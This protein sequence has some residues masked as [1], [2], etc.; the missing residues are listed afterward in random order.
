MIVYNIFREKKRKF[1]NL[2]RYYGNN[3]RKTDKETAK[4][5]DWIKTPC[6]FTENGVVYTVEEF[7]ESLLRW[8]FLFRLYGGIP[9]KDIK[10]LI[11]LTQLGIS[12]IA[13]LGGFIWL[14]VWLKQRFDLGVWVVLV[15]IFV[16]IVCAV[17]GRAASRVL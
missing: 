4:R 5:K 9:L 13:P 6:D 14:S 11:W 8:Q 2:F 7:G 17:D 16:G 1:H 3:K 15:G 10:L 12:I